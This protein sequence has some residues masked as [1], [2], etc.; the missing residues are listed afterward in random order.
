M[1][2]IWDGCCMFIYTQT[3]NRGWIF[4]ARVCKTSSMIFGIDWYFDFVI[5][6][7]EN[8]VPQKYLDWNVRSIF[9]AILEI[10]K[11]S[12]IIAR[13]NSFNILKIKT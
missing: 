7:P 3:N 4:D 11:N 9:R 2:I 12:V 6:N 8:A 13:Q 5:A 10:I 1:F